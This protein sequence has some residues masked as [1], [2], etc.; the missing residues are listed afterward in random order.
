M[1]VY[2]YISIT[3]ITNFTYS[4][5]EP[6]MLAR[7]LTSYAT[8]AQYNYSTTLPH[9]PH[10]PDQSIANIIAPLLQYHTRVHHNPKL[11]PLNPNP[12]LKPS[13]GHETIAL[14]GS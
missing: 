8:T 12:K 2:I 1:C 3:S 14:S 10:D 13:Q 9:K 11:T 6:S 5:L 4:N 7:F